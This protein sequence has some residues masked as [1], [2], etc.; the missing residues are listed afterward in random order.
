MSD[1]AR[2]YE[3]LLSRAAAAAQDGRF[4][5]A[6]ALYRQAITLDSAR[7]EAWAGIGAT[8]SA[9]R[10]PEAALA[11]WEAAIA[12]APRHAPSLCAKAAVHRSMGQAAAARALNRAALAIDPACTAAL[13]GEI[14]LDVDAGQVEA[15]AARLAAIPAVDRGR[16]VLWAAARVSLSLGRYAAAQAAVTD[17][18]AIGGLTAGQRAEALV[19]L[20]EI[21]GE[22]GDTAAAFRAAVAGKQLWHRLYA[23]RAAG[24]ES[25]AAKSLRLGRWWG[26]ADAAA[27]SPAPRAAAADT[28]TAARGHVFLVGF[29]RSGTTL[30]EQILAGHPHVVALEEAPTFAEHYAEFLAGD[31]GCARLAALT[32]TEADHWRARYWATVA[33]H[34]ADA[35]G[36]VFVDKAPAGTLYLP[37]V[38]RLFPDAKILF[39]VR[40]PRDVVLSCLRNAFQMNAMTYGFTTL[41]GTAACYDAVMTMAAAYRRRLP[42][43]LAEVRHEALVDDLPGEI[44]RIVAFLDLAPDPA[45]ADVAATA[46]RRDVRTPS[47][48]QVREGVTP[49]GIGRWRTYAAELA[50]VLPPLARWV[51]AF[52]YPPS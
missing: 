23:E 11:A 48:R 39:A 33:A 37:L 29:P 21:L 8:E 40:D 3:L 19:L 2:S 22:R 38:A 49:R 46:A 12:R 43:P 52:G 41:T 10:R 34:G 4:D 36:R 18:L 47:A 27:W 35:R 51:A 16:D 7:F 25:E 26:A 5:P 13:L 31:D 42:L 1:T 9:A 50:P 14:A 32:A 6:L 20:G 44:A 30:L 24:R 28:A 17:L 15:A 45:M